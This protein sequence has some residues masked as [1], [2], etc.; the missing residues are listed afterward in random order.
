MHSSGLSSRPSSSNSAGGFSSSVSGSRTTVPSGPRPSAPLG[1][2]GTRWT[3]CAG[4]GR[5]V[6]VLHWHAETVAE[7]PKVSLG[8]L[9]AENAAQR[10]VL[11]VGRLGGGQDVGQWLAHVVEVRGLEFANIGQEAG[12]GEPSPQRER[13]ADVDD[14]AEA[15]EQRVGVEHRHGH[16]AHVELGEVLASSRSCVRCG[17]ICL[18]T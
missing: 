7:A 4:F 11:V 3:R 13:T 12:R 1:C 15:G 10:V 8:A 17:P 18:A 9:V 2:S 5:A 16:V 6:V 14:R